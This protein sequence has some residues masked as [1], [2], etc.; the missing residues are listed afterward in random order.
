[1]KN[2]A[3]ALL[4][5]ICAITT[6]LGC[7]TDIKP[8]AFIDMLNDPS[9][10]DDLAFCLSDDPE[11]DGDNIVIRADK[12]CLVDLSNNRT[13]DDLTIEMISR[14]PTSYMDRQLTFSAAVK[15]ISAWGDPP[16]I[17]NIELYT[18]NSDVRFTIHTRDSVVGIPIEKHAIYLWTCRIY[19]VEKT[20]DR[21][22]W[23]VNAEFILSADNQI[24][25]HPQLIGW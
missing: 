24:E 18:N 25:H 15:D 1:V 8:S 17:R 19:Q 7:D 20:A 6:M 16:E 10:I 4:I 9:D 13:S 21:G 2:F 23:Q 11:T 22:N 3:L 5:L 14:M 12:Q